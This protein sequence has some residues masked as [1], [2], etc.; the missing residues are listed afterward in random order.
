MFVGEEGSFD[1]T[2]AGLSSDSVV[3]NMTSYFFDVKKPELKADVVRL[4]YIGKTPGFIPGTFE[5]KSQ[6]RKDSV[7]STFPRFKS[8]QSDL[9]ITGLADGNV[10]YRGGFSLIGNSISSTSVT[11]DPATIEVYKDGEKKFTARS[12]EFNFTP[13]NIISERTKVNIHQGNDSLVHQSVRLKYTYGPDSTQQLLLLKDK[14]DMRNAPYSSTFFNVDF[15]ADAIRWDLYSDSLNIQIDGA[16][17]TVPVIIESINFYDPE[18]Y[19]L[20]KGI[21]FRFHPLA[22]V[23]NYALKNKV[24]EF[25][26]W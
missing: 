2:P 1:W 19:R 14:G 23:A 5:F 17:N 22:L 21:G 12:A 18:D 9:V 6:S 26:S 10:R 24:R 3:C 4:N 7:L 25:Y 20:L 13:G 11:G 16:R 15:S 8:Y